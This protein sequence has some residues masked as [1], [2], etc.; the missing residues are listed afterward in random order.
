VRGSS[1]CRAK[2][3]PGRPTQRELRGRWQ[4]LG[5]ER[6]WPPSPD[7]RLGQQRARSSSVFNHHD[8]DAAAVW[9]ESH[10]APARASYWSQ[11]Q[12]EARR[13]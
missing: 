4:D 10:I 5:S 12:R 6:G 8:V 9:R 11:P 7:Q 2:R 13:L 1:Q 3:R